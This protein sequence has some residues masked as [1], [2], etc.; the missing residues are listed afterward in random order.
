MAGAL[1][2]S[3]QALSRKRAGRFDDGANAPQEFGG[4]GSSDKNDDH[5]EPEH[6]NFTAC[7]VHADGSELQQNHA[8]SGP[9]GEPGQNSQRQRQN[10]ADRSKDLYHTDERDQTGGGHREPNAIPSDPERLETG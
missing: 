10:Y 1:W 4:N 6:R 2:P 5:V 3:L 9:G 8:N 7:K